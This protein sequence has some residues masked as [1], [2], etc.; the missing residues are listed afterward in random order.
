MEVLEPYLSREENAEL[1]KQIL[2]ELMD[3]LNTLDEQKKGDCVARD[4]WGR[5]IRCISA[6]GMLFFSLLLC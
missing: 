5:T 4:A 1:T 2:Q 3:L 6:I